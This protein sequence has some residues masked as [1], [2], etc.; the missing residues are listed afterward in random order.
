MNNGNVIFTT[1]GITQN[2]YTGTIT[3]FKLHRQ[4][5]YKEIPDGNNNYLSVFTGMQKKVATMTIILQTSGS[6][7]ILPA[8]LQPATL[9]STTSNDV[10]GL[11]YVTGQPSIVWKHDDVVKADVEVTQFISSTG[12]L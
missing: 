10:T 11:W 2:V 5:E 8:P 6:T 9:T 4:A 1:N 7:V 12:T 3:D